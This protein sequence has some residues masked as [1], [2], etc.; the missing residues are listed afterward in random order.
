MIQA[1]IF[2]LD[3]V[4][5]STDEC[6]YQAWR[7]MAEGQGIPFD[8]KVNERLRGVSRMQSLDIILERAARAYSQEEK[9][10]LA[11][12]KNESYVRM[13]GR[14]DAGSLLPGA[15]ETLASLRKREIPAAVGSSSRNAR[16]IL[17]QLGLE[18]YF[19]AVADGN[20][21]SRSKPDP[22]VFLVAAGKLGVLPERC[23]VVED[24]LSGVD[25]ALG[26]NMQVLAV[27]P[28]KAHPGA[29]LTAESLADIDLAARIDACN[30]GL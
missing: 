1:V 9:Q 29:A 18:A 14:L 30:A 13:I 5:V 23:L 2:D 21:I 11:R 12:Q 8:R 19:R 28:A 6:H 16:A 22:E 15:I 20:D 24:A 10:A 4:L 26:A 7:E 27:G 17:Q 3:G 25:A